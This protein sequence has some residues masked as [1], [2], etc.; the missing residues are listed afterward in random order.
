MRLSGSYA[1]APITLEFSV[2]IAGTYPDNNACTSPILILPREFD[3][4]PILDPSDVS[5]LMLS[6]SEY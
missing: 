5:I 2:F 1:I 3:I 4:D 6:A